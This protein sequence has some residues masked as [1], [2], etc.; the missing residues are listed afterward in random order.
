MFVEI[1]SRKRIPDIFSLSREES[2][3]LVHRKCQEAGYSFHLSTLITYLLNDCPTASSA[4]DLFGLEKTLPNPLPQ[5]H[6]VPDTSVLD[7]NAATELAPVPVSQP[8]VVCRSRVEAD[9]AL[10]VC[11]HRLCPVCLHGAVAQQGLLCPKCKQTT[12]LRDIEVRTDLPE[13][14]KKYVVGLLGRP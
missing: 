12:V 5:H 6:N 9:L 1:I 7:T 2:W 3:D 10:L 13:K 14:I 11:Q 4:L 8:C